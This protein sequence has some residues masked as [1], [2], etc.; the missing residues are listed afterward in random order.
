[1]S[2]P[3]QFVGSPDRW[4]DCGALLRVLRVA[5]SEHAAYAAAARANRLMDRL[6][7][8]RRDVSSMAYDGGRYAAE[9][10]ADTAPPFFPDTPPRC[11]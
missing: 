3:D 6:Q 1:M 9:V 5:P 8:G 2:P 10:F 11:E 4:Y 7:R